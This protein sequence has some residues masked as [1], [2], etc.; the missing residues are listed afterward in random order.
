VIQYI[1]L[2]SIKAIDNGF[3]SIHLLYFIS[4]EYLILHASCFITLKIPCDERPGRCKW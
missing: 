4:I 3:F 2:C 1:T